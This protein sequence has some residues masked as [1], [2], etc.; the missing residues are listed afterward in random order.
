[1]GVREEDGERVSDGRKKINEKCYFKGR[2]GKNLRKGEK[3]TIQN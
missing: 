1:M 3:R 2:R